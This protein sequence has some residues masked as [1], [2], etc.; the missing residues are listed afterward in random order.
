MR[1]AIILQ[2]HMAQWQSCLCVIHCD[3]D[4]TQIEL[5]YCN[6]IF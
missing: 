3:V 5:H 2:R 6:L 1:G 4:R